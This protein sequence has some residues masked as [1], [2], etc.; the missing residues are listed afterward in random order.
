MCRDWRRCPSSRGERKRAYQRARY[1]AKKAEAAHESTTTP[2]SRG[3]DMAVAGEGQVSASAAADAAAARSAAAAAARY[4]APEPTTAVG[5]VFAAAAA[6][7]E[8]VAARLDDP[9]DPL[10]IDPDDTSESAGTAREAVVTMLCSSDLSDTQG[11]DAWVSATCSR[12]HGEVVAAASIE[13]AKD[14]HAQTDEL[15][16][17]ARDEEVSKAV[18]VTG[19]AISVGTGIRTS[20]AF[21]DHLRER[22]SRVSGHYGSSP[23]IAADDA[24]MRAVHDGFY[25]DGDPEKARQAMTAAVTGLVANAREGTSPEEAAAA[26]EKV[27]G[28]Y[29]EAFPEAKP[30]EDITYDDVKRFNDLVK[31]NGSHLAEYDAKEII[32]S[33][34]DETM[35]AEFKKT[36]QSNWW[37]KVADLE[38]RT[39]D[40]NVD[41]LDRTAYA[42]ACKASMVAACL[43][44]GHVKVTGDSDG[45]WTGKRYNAM[46]S[47]VSN[48]VSSGTDNPEKT[49]WFDTVRSALD[50]IAPRFED[51]GE[52]DAIAVKNSQAKKSDMDEVKR[53][54]SLYSQRDMERFYDDFGV[55]EWGQRRVKYM[56]IE[57]SKKRAHFRARDTAEIDTPGRTAY[58]QPSTDVLESYLS[59]METEGHADRG[60]GITS[61]GYAYVDKDEPS[62]VRGAGTLPKEGDDDYVERRQELQDLV[63]RFNALPAEDRQRLG[64]RR[65]KAGHKLMVDTAEVEVYGENGKEVRSVAYIRSTAKLPSSMSKT[66][67]HV[68]TVR[69]NDTA[70]TTHHEVAHMVDHYVGVNNDIAQEFLRE[71]VGDLDAV[72]YP[73]GKSDEMVV[74]DSFYDHYVGKTSYGT[75]ASEI[76][77]MGVEVLMHSPYQ[78]REL[79]SLPKRDGKP[80]VSYAPAMIDPEHHDHTLGLLAGTPRTLSYNKNGDVTEHN[81]RVMRFVQRTGGGGEFAETARVYV[82]LFD[83]DGNRK[84]TSG[85]SLMPLRMLD[86]MVADGQPRA[87]AAR[88]WLRENTGG[89]N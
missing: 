86:E 61:I 47:S 56:H 39:K 30:L 25:A 26:V 42:Q 3:V 17:V 46:H 65:R 16:A 78:A 2:G 68:S 15:A 89:E 88:A 40:D 29:T 6:T 53:A 35:P 27:L 22:A 8:D 13:R 85:M 11:L 5:R 48:Y 50:E 87:K 71:R 62:S 82:P 44:G 51:S 23:L 69:V 34:A 31:E 36:F 76:N 54:L 74:A 57:K 45:D 67:T 33:V 20:H 66:Y 72:H 79:D 19:R 38:E 81:T 58:L 52:F 43:A 75:R 28:Q 84:E 70:D 14:L 49:I 41:N 1:A 4:T 55:D 73:G 59:V 83:D 18:R 63:D 12:E 60:R 64:D 10:Y 21:E 37:D 7:P 9:T 77:S 32:A 80:V 24:N